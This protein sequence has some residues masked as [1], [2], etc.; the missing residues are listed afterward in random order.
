MALTI[1]ICESNGAGETVTHALTNCNFGASDSANLTRTSSRIA[2]TA[3]SYEKYWRV[4]VSNIGGLTSVSDIR[5][6]KSYGTLG[7]G[8][9]VDAN[10]KTSSYS[11]SSYATPVNTDSSKATTT[12]PTSYPAS[13]NLGIS[14]SLA[15]TLTAAGYSD[16]MVAQIT[17]SGATGGEENTWAIIFR[18][19]VIV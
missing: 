14:G 8:V 18:A 19:K 10:L 12:M 13:A 7:T 4:H 16:Y 6:W 17:T 15:S 2:A 11:S 5:I 1:E 9:T 3:Y